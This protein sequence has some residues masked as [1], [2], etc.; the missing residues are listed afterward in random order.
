[1]MMNR[2]RHIRQH[3]NTWIVKSRRSN[4]AYDCRAHA[5]N[6]VNVHEMNRQQS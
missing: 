5:V 6:A 3:V 2:A 4:G 1:M